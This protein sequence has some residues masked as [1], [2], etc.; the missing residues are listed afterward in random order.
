MSRCR[1]SSSCEGSIKP[2]AAGVQTAPTAND[3]QSPKEI[4][5]STSVS[6][7]DILS[8]SA[9]LPAARDLFSNYPPKRGLH[10]SIN[11]RRSNPRDE[12]SYSSIPTPACD[13]GDNTQRATMEYAA[14]PR[15]EARDALSPASAKG[16]FSFLNKYDLSARSY[17]GNFPEGHQLRAEFVEAYQLDDELGSG[18]YSFVMTARDRCDGY[19]V[20]VKFIIKE[21][22]PDHCWIKDPTYGKLP[23]EFVLLSYV[24]HENIV[25]CLDVYEDPLFFYLVQELHGSPW[26]REDGVALD[27]CSSSSASST[28]LSTP[29]LSPSTS[30]TSLNHPEPQTPPQSSHPSLPVTVSDGSNASEEDIFA[31]PPS[32]EYLPKLP[33][34]E[35]CRRPSYDLFECIEQSEQK[36]LSE[37]Q[38]RYVF[39]QVVDV[40]HYLNSLGIVHRDI[41]D[42]NVVIDQ[43]LKIKL[44][45]FGSATICDPAHPAPDYDQFYGT[46]AYA[47]SEILLKKKYKAAP[48]EVWTLGVLLSYLLAGVSPFPTVRDAVEGKIFLSESLCLKPCD[49]AM[50]LIRRCLD[51]NPN[52]RICIDEIKSHP[53]LSE[54][55]VP[56]QA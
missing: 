35:P 47:S 38:A 53:W 29:A 7:A 31:M 3:R 15:S 17:S 24:N 14:T 16:E 43:N 19:E 1:S 13:F 2:G 55:Q 8:K 4:G 33:A 6:S 30:T 51:P 11:T 40:V 52:T 12:I 20:A 37:S 10:L 5:P 27:W 9:S 21:K 54:C 45:D 56:V 18:G 23:M 25:K 32:K 50:D 36:R 46:A 41:K 39:A 44:I 22:V 28:S 34:H 49:S 48:A 42:E 26:H